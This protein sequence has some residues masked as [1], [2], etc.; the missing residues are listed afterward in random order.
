[1][2]ERTLRGAGE[3]VRGRARARA[4]DAARGDRALSFRITELWAFIAVGD[5]DEEGVIGAKMPNGSWLP[6]VMADNR[7]LEQLRPMAE[8]IAEASGKTVRLVRFSVREDIETLGKR[9][10]SS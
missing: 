3:A 7:R 4:R 10:T 1:M 5:D 9:E 8:D 6:F 2:E